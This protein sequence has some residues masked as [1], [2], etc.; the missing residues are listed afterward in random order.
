VI[1]DALRIH[2]LLAGSGVGADRFITNNQ[3]D[4]GGA[5]TELRVT[6]PADLAE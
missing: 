1:D 4:F 3:R 2:E 6:Y 5:I